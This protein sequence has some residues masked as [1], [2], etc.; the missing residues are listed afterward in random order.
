MM[1]LRFNRTNRTRAFN[2]EITVDHHL[3]CFEYIFKMQNFVALLSNAV[4]CIDGPA[5]FQNLCMRIFLCVHD[6]MANRVAQKKMHFAS[7]IHVFVNLLC[8]RIIHRS[9]AVTYHVLFVREVADDAICI[10]A[11][12]Q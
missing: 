4:M 7:L 1:S 12:Q 3:C 6:H 11:R 10:F 5:L 2:F 8:N 9:C